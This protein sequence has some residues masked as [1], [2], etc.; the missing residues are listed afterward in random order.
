[1]E[2]NEP[3]PPSGNS[4]SLPGAEAKSGGRSYPTRV[5]LSRAG[6]MILRDLV[7]GGG[8]LLSHVTVPSHLR[9]AARTGTQH[10][11]FVH[12]PPLTAPLTSLPSLL[13]TPT[14]APVTIHR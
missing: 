12:T 2:V 13:I 8:G 6:Y 14:A 4:V 5:S 11:L 10:A 1:M 9:L 3:D 7:P